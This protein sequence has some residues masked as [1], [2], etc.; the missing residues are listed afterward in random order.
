MITLLE[1]LRPEVVEALEKNRDKYDYCITE[2][3]ESLDNKY[4]YSELS[5]GEMRDL[6]LWADIDERT[7]G[8]VDWKYG[9]KL[10]RDEIR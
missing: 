7:W 10:F 6:I 2:L 5:V 1:Q 8:Y 4:L 9:I 3:Y